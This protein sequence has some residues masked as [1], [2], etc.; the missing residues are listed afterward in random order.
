MDVNFGIVHFLVGASQRVG[1]I[2]LF[3][4]AIDGLGIAIQKLDLL[5]NYGYCRRCN[6]IPLIYGFLAD[7]FSLGEPT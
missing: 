3:G 6:I 2:L 4:L 5:F 7:S 1:F